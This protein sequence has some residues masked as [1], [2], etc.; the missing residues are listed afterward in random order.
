[1]FEYGAGGSTLYFSQYVEKYVSIEHNINWFNKMQG[2]KMPNNVD[3]RYC[4]PNNQIKLPVWHGSSA[5][6]HDY[7]CF[8]DTIPYKHYDKVLIDGRA[9]KQCGEK[10]LD[11]ISAESIVFVHDFFE[12]KRYHELMQFYRIIDQDKDNNP[13]LAVFQKL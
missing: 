10:I 8:I 1:M 9:R 12:R 4:A 13:S 2:H 6:F 7:I 5:D 11:Y 3:L